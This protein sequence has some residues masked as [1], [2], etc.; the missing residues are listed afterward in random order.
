MQPCQISAALSI[1]SHTQLWFSVVL[2]AGPLELLS[3]AALLTKPVLFEICFF[4]QCHLPLLALPLFF[5]IISIS[6]Y[7]HF[8]LRLQ[9]LVLSPL[10]LLSGSKQ[11]LLELLVVSPNFENKSCFQYMQHS[12]I[13]AL[14]K[15]FATKLLNSY[16][17]T[18]C[19]KEFIFNLC[20]LDD[21]MHFYNG[22]S[23]T[24]SRYIQINIYMILKLERSVS[25]FKHQ[26]VSLF[27]SFP[28]IVSWTE[29]LM[30]MIIA[31]WLI[32]PTVCDNILL[33][34]LF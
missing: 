13:S 19:T 26:T 12:S 11:N 34:V 18:T 27:L 5:F 1:L 2:Q 6:L 9:R 33:N 16:F 32:P 24:L 21:S 7:D 4:E 29:T 22:T 31:T 8:I 30:V 14:L 3:K 17:M 28:L 23:S 10:V 25:S 15:E 20:I